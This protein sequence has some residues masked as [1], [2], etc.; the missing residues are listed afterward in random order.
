MKIFYLAIFYFFIAFETSAQLY[1]PHAPTPYPKCTTMPTNCSVYA[2]SNGDWNN[3]STWSTGTPPTQDQIVCIPA[4]TTVDLSGIYNAP[5]LQ[6]FVC[7]TL[8]F[9]F[10]APG[11]LNLAQWSFIQVYAGGLIN[12]RSGNAELISIGGI[13][14]WRDNNSDI[15]GPWVLS[16]PYIGA[17]VLT[18]AFDYFKASQ[19]Q[20]YQV[21]LDWGTLHEINNNVFIVERSND[22][23]L[24][25]S[26]GS[27]KA[28]GN[29]SQ[30]QGYSFTDKSPIAGITYYRLKQI[31][32]KGEITYSSII[33]FNAVIAKKF[34]LFPNPVTSS[35]QLFSKEGFT[36]SQTVI[37]LDSKGTVVRKLNPMGINSL[38]LDLSNLA[39]GLYL[40]HV[41]DR[42]QIIEKLSFVKQ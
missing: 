21:Q 41:I 34:S 36:S 40:I 39:N 22:Q 25:N 24:W 26:I 7:G 1:W 38:Q 42:N 14:V 9:D 33:R 6:I 19:P 5:R 23:K 8:N 17:G 28:V 29:S 18:I 10:N 3:G 4:G 31:D 37:I 35:T 11:K 13:D 27:V 30:K 32:Y 12:S 2:V 15:N 20:P 16:W